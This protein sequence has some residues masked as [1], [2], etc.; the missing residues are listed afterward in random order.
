MR[1][2]TI[3]FDEHDDLSHVL[4]RFREACRKAR[5]SDLECTVGEDC[6]ESFHAILVSASER[7]TQAHV[8]QEIGSRRSRVL[9]V[10]MSSQRRNSIGRRLAPWIG[11]FVGLLFIAAVVI[12]LV[13]T[14]LIGR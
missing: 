7:G 5:V 11:A 13:Q 2:H 1:Y 3:E 10:A 14:V 9:L 6:V 12:I 4:D 8:E